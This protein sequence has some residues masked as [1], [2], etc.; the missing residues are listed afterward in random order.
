M[1][2]LLFAAMAALIPVMLSSQQSFDVKITRKGTLMGAGSPISVF[3]DNVEKG[4]LKGTSELTVNGTLPA[5]SIIELRF[6][7]P[8]KKATKFFLYPNNSF[9]YLI[10]AKV[11]FGGINLRDLSEYPQGASSG[12]AE[13]QNVL[14]KGV[15]VNKKNLSVSYVNEKT[16]KSDEIRKQWARQGGDMVGRS[17]SYL[18]TYAKS[19]LTTSGTTTSTMIIGAGWT[20]TQNH[21]KITI[22]EYKP[23]IATWNSLVYGMGA[24]VN[25]H[26]AQTDIK[27]KP[28]SDFEPFV[29]GS[30]VVMLNGNFGY[31]L[32]LGKF[33]TETTYN[34]LALELTYKPS[35]VFSGSEG[36]SVTQFNFKGVGFDISRNSFSAYAN[37]IA[38]KAKS[39]FS[40]LFLPPIK[41]TPF[42]ISF[43]YGLVWYR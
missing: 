41:D 12:K 21:Y 1:K 7:I 34:G 18:G 14:P 11:S 28:Y 42:M 5:D 24:S 13:Q 30:L 16:L 22:P 29:G 27:P 4:K 37:R 40:F 38:P 20:Y 43:G 31:T 25:V 35:M 19:T 10:S 3:Y 6:R 9:S 32:G 33:K 15:T 39:K 23:G 17:L 36:G 2:R 8:L 26:M